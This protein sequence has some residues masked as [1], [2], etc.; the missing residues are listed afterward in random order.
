[1][2]Y[3]YYIYNNIVLTCTNAFSW[4]P[5]AQ[6]PRPRVVR[7]EERGRQITPECARSVAFR[8]SAR[9]WTTRGCARIPSVRRRV[10]E[11]PDGRTISPIADV[12][13]VTHF[14]GMGRSPPLA[15]PEEIAYNHHPLTV[16]EGG[17]ARVRDRRYASRRRMSAEI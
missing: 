9:R 3:L 6:R 15:P 14:R 11:T 1:M 4:R 5:I 10:T 16:T 13:P 7:N 2:L 8:V 12:R 17:G